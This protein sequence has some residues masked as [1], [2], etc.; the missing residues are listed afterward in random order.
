M[1]G[2]H[3]LAAFQLEIFLGLLFMSAVFF[4]SSVALV[5]NVG[6]GFAASQPGKNVLVWCLRDCRWFRGIFVPMDGSMHVFDGKDTEYIDQKTGPSSIQ[7]AI[8]RDTALE[9]ATPG[10]NAQK[11]VGRRTKKFSKSLNSS[12]GLG[13]G[14]S[15]VIT[16]SALLTLVIIAAGLPAAFMKHQRNEAQKVAD[17]GVQPFPP[18]K[19]SDRTDAELNGNLPVTVDLA[20]A[21]RAL[22]YTTGHG[23]LLAAAGEDWTPIR[24][25]FISAIHNWKEGQGQEPPK[26]QEEQHLLFRQIMAQDLACLENAAVEAK[27]LVDVEKD[28]FEDSG[29]PGAAPYLAMMQARRRQAEAAILWKAAVDKGALG[30]DPRFNKSVLRLLAAVHSKAVLSE[31]LNFAILQAREPPQQSE[32]E[33]NEAGEAFGRQVELKHIYNAAKSMNI[34]GQYV[35]RDPVVMAELGDWLAILFVAL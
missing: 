6:G 11:A 23:I 27:H 31:H 2:K 10:R 15:G 28:G 24:D 12:L 26:K 7:T 25:R 22:E 17:S 20:N 35:A 30:N 32:E 8:G 19:L 18:E 16:V 1:T 33:P 13:E 21:F 34:A 29:G 14:Y 9:Q 3:L 4:C 5:R